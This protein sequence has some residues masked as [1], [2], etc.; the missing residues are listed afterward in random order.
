MTCNEL[1]MKIERLRAKMNSLGADR[2]DYAK[3]L[4]VSQVLDKLIVEYYRAVA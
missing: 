2:A 3:M 4:E 1:L